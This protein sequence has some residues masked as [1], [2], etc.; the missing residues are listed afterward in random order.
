MKKQKQMGIQ[1]GIICLAF[2]IIFL[3]VNI[4][5][6]MNDKVY[7]VMLIL[8]PPLIFSG[9]G[10]LVLPGIKVP[11]EIAEKERPKYWWKNSPIQHK[12]V[13][14]IEMITGLAIGIWLMVSYTK[15]V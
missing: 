15:F 4:V 7:P 5:M 11:P 6:F 13:W 1:M 3:I 12:L 14:I 9:V 2:G 8:S 10:F